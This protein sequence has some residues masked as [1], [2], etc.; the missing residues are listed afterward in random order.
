VDRSG[1]SLK[2]MVEWGLHHP[3]ASSDTLIDVLG[4]LRG[5][6]EVPV[7]VAVDGVNALYETSVY[8]EEGSGEPLPGHRL[9]VPAAFQCLGPEGFK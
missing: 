5:V 7:L 3:S 9:T 2:D 1:F 8:P 6:T 4:E